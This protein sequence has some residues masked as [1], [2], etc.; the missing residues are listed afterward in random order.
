MGEVLPLTMFNL[1]KLVSKW[2]ICLECKKSF[3]RSE[4]PKGHKIIHMGAKVHKCIEC[5]NTFGEAG[6]LKRHMVTHNG[7]KTHICSKCQKSFG[8]ADNLR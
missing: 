1:K 5:G 4:N 3:G 6:N 2:V 8:R 7:A